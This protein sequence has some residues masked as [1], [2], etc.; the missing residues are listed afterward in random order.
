MSQANDFK[1]TAWASERKGFT[2]K[3]ADYRRCIQPPMS[4]YKPRADAKLVGYIDTNQGPVKA[5]EFRVEFEA[6]DFFLKV[7]ELA[8]AI[9]KVYQIAGEPFQFKPEVAPQKTDVEKIVDAIH[10]I[11]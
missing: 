11:D 2:L 6:E 9:E 8:E 7:T 5:F 3:V 1:P 10:T 4:V